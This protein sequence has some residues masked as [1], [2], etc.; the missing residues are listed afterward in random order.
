MWIFGCAGEEE[1]EDDGNRVS[2]GEAKKLD[3]H[4]FASVILITCLPL[5]SIFSF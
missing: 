5:K 3:D 2:L 1:E 4:I